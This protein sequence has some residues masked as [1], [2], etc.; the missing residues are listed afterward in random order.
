MFVGE[1]IVVFVGD[2]VG[3]VIEVPCVI[4]EFV[5]D[6]VQGVFVVE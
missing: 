1:L 6:H 3:D 2:V 5:I 4:F